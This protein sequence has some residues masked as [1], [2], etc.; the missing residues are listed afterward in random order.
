MTIRL[1]EADFLSVEE[2]AELPVEELRR[3]FRLY[4]EAARYGIDANDIDD[5]LDRADP[6]TPAEWVVAIRTARGICPKCHG[7]GSYSWG[8]CINGKMSHSG[9]CFR[10]EGKGHVDVSDCRRNRGYD[11]HAIRR[12]F[13]QMS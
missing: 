1:V 7:S 9:E 3:L 4:R 12:A 2:L 5:C 10:C 8:A 6:Q 11:G 13:A